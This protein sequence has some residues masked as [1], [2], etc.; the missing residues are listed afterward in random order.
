VGED[1]TDLLISDLHDR[2]R[3]LE[4]SNRENRRI[5]AALTQRILAIEAPS[6]APETTE[7]ASTGTGRG[8][9]PSDQEP[10]A[11]PSWWGSRWV[12]A[13]IAILVVVGLALLIALILTL[14]QVVQ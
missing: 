5:I 12:D 1:R 6:D 8:T 3:S 9:V 14:T 4:E 7:P 2:V 11:H 13:V 10:V